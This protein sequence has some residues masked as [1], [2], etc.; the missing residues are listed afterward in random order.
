[1]SK[2]KRKES[3]IRYETSIPV[4]STHWQRLPSEYA[5]RNLPDASLCVRPCGAARDSLQVLHAV[6]R[7][8]IRLQ[9]ASAAAMG[10]ICSIWNRRYLGAHA[11]LSPMG[12]YVYTLAFINLI[13]IIL[14]L[15]L[16]ASEPTGSTGS[17]HTK[18][19]SGRTAIYFFLGPFKQKNCNL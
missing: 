14:Y 13:D 6:K 10:A 19:F 8:R 17:V 9:I 5:S 12:A 16:T 18:K 15:Y 4:E 11:N 1:M 3:Q 2:R 7:M